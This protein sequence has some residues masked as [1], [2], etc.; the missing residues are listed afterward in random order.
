MKKRTEAIEM[1]FYRRMLRMP[2][3]EHMSNKE[4]LK[5]IETKWTPILNIR[6]R[7]LKFLWRIMKK[8]ELEKL[9]NYR[10]G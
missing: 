8:R 3:T 4:L 10:T 9:D 6:K 2:W 5:T 1:W 7:Q